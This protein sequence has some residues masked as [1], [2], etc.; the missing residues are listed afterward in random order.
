MM[1]KNHAAKRSWR[2]LALALCLAMLV[3]LLP[4]VALAAVD[5][6]WA[7]GKT[8]SS[9]TTLSGGTESKPYTFTV[10]GTVTV[11]E[12]IQVTGYVRITGGGTLLRGN[13]N[14][15]NAMF[16]V[17]NGA[18]LI[19]DN[20]T[21][22]GNN[23]ATTSQAYCG[24]NVNQYGKL[25]M[26]EGAVLKNH[27]KDPSV[28][29]G[30]ALYVSGTV[31]VN[32]GEIAGC[33][34]K[35]RG[36]IYLSDDAQFTMNGGK[37]HDNTLTFNGSYGGGAFYVRGGTLTINGG[38][39]Y[40]HK[41]IPNPGGAI[42]C[43]S[44]GT[45]NLNGGTIENNTVASDK[46]GDA[47][48][49]SSQ[50]GDGG[51]IYISG[52]PLITNS[53]Y[54]DNDEATKYPYITS[55]IKNPLT[56][57]VSGYEEGRVIAQ[58]YGGYRLTEA[59]MEN[60]TLKVGNTTYY[61]KL[62]EANN[63]LVMTAT[64]PTYEKKYYVTYDANGGGVDSTHPG[65]SDNMPYK[66]GDTATILANAFV[67]NGWEFTGW[68]T[69]ADGT[70]TSYY[71][72]NTYTMTASN[73]A[74]YA[75]WEELPK[76]D[77]LKINGVLMSAGEYIASNDTKVSENAPTE[78]GYAYLSTDGTLTLHNFVLD[79]GSIRVQ[80]A[81]AA[82]ALT[83]K[84]EGEN[85]LSSGVLSTED[86]S[87][88]HPVNLTI[89]GDGKLNV[90]NTGGLTSIY[91]KKGDV[92][93]TGG[94]DVTLKHNSGGAGET[95]HAVNGS[96]NISGTGT[97]LNAVNTGSYGVRTTSGV[98][99]DNNAK[100]Y[101]SGSSKALV[102]GALTA[103]LE[104]VQVSNDGKTFAQASALSDALSHKYVKI[105]GAP[106]KT[107]KVTWDANE[108]TFSGESAK[109]ED[110]PYGTSITKPTDPTRSGY[111]FKGWTAVK[112]GATLITDF[113]TVTNDVTYYAK[114]EAAQVTTHTITWDANGGTL[115]GDYTNGPVNYGTQIVAPT[116]SKAADAQYTYT[117][118]GWYTEAEGGTKVTSFGTV[119]ENVTYYAHWT[120]VPQVYT[121]TLNANGGT[122]NN[123]NVTSY[124]YG[125]G[126]TLPTVDDMTYAGHT[127]KGWY[128][129][130]GFSGNPV[131]EISTTATGAKT[132]YAKW[133]STDAGITAV[134]VDNTAGTINGT[135]I[136]VVLPYGTVALPTENSKVSI[137]AADGAT[138]SGLTTTDGSEWT[139]TVTAADGQT[140][141]NYTISVSIAPDPATGNRNDIAAA[142]STVENHDW[143]VPQATANTEE[144]VKTWIEGQLAAMNLNGASY[145]VTMTGF[146]TATEGTA[147]DRD[148]TNG[149]FTFT[150][151][152]YKGNDTGNIATSTYAEATVT[153][154]NGTVTATP[155]T[156]WTVTVN[157]GN[158]GSV[159]GS[160]TFEE[161]TQVT[162]TAT[163]NSGYH[164]VRWTENGAEV[165]TSASY[166]FILT[167]DHTLVAV[168]EQDAPTTPTKHTVTV[169]GSYATNSGAGQYADGV[170]V[171]I[172]AGSRS[173]YT[174][175]GWTAT[176]ITLS[177]PNSATISFTMPGNNVTVM[178]NWRQNSST[179]GS[180]GGGGSSSPSYTVST[181]KDTE[182]GSYTVRPSRAERGDTVTITTKPD[183]GYQVGKVT[184]TDKN[185]DT[186]KV[187]NKGGGV[188]TFTMPASAVSVDVTFVAEKQWTNPFADVAKDAWYY[189]AV[190]YVNENGLM[191]GTSANTS[192][193]TFAPDLT[194][195]R[196]MIVTIL[197]RLAGS[198][199]IKDQIWGYPYADVDSTA[200]YGTAV[201]WARLSGIAAGYS[202]EQFGPNDTITREQMATILYRYAQYKGY[203]LTVK[204]NLDTFKDAD[205]ITDYA[206]TAMQWAVG[207]GLVKG[208]SGNL[209]DPQG[210]A[211]RAEIAAMLHRF[212]EKY[213]LV[214]GKAP[215]GLMG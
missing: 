28:G 134:S 182:N 35:N 113:G 187:A 188:Y 56:L 73:F 201:Y 9:T 107:Q 111:K 131:T 79:T 198:P 148:G 48:F 109:S 85:V 14:T 99:V 178:A 118:D 194:T 57:V 129:D 195:T 3:G 102:G 1:K 127:F 23:V 40:N 50:E 147:A 44:Y 78:G 171:T 97:T 122:I 32:G 153:I 64:K 215:G 42:Y 83:I 156:K 121:V 135:T 116:A 104:K 86:A 13:G 68:N 17:R 202:S 74:L 92:T 144:A 199:D 183:E 110:L 47:I 46:C 7:D 155:Y 136:T 16:S 66:A 130:S 213:E 210:M 53:I 123:G 30:S 191:A 179:G 75:Q 143:T 145:T 208:K 105:N 27:K 196:G 170:T 43:S 167:A 114:W 212:I 4:T 61:A 95:V 142:K 2:V 19:L 189:D 139:F 37:I 55:T 69:N 168:F 38:S 49:Y 106:T 51:A 203:D 161:N 140:I 126:A 71:A 163:P 181:D 146:T 39:I 87:N 174:F 41:N 34:C 125:V 112:D 180:S 76:D 133:L 58:G 100:V 176:G 91:V 8:I 18:T 162:V 24:V 60:V 31:E 65:T 94:A 214:Q 22:D 45:V 11:N 25:V 200:Y 120:P 158:G 172:N 206:K 151:K 108:G 138:V 173:G 154:S 101:I 115:S 117:F 90:E 52:N 26:E 96:I 12:L 103:T 159:S 186:V 197:Y 124:T 128:E 175:T 193:N 59:D 119:T 36:N 211:T 141:K 80:S 160:G 98:T 207:S 67:R 84:L 29:L 6:T 89:T 15:T 205:K 204:G 70:G 62:D 177:S 152:L 192:A 169:N 137:T 82:N 132:Y 63:Q 10:T 5:E 72:N 164:F 166:S 190:K 21:V 93:V 209:L 20:I 184:V 185:G 33:S 54:L 150:V 77:V 157:A 88:A 165:S 149:S 81:Y